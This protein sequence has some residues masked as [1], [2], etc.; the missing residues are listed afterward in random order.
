[1][2]KPDE[3]ALGVWM[4]IRSIFVS[5]RNHQAAARSRNFMRCSMAMRSSSDVM[6]TEVRRIH[7]G[8]ATAAICKEDTIRGNLR[9]GFYCSQE[10]INLRERDCKTNHVYV[11]ITYMHRGRISFLVAVHKRGG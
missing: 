4:T 5:D 3:T 8:L 9:V 10:L 11:S 1:M 2:H 6:G 7:G